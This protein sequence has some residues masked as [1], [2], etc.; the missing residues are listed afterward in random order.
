MEE[1]TRGGGR[2]GLGKEREWEGGV[3]GRKEAGDNRTL[4]TA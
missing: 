2:D 4:W 1:F 3:R